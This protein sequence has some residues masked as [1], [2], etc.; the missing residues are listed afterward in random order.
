MKIEAI[1][2]ACE[3]L[4]MADNAGIYFPLCAGASGSLFSASVDPSPPPAPSFKASCWPPRH[5]AFRG[6]AQGSPAAAAAATATTAA[7]AAATAAAAATTAAATAT[8]A[9]ATAT[10]AAVAAEVLRVRTCGSS[11]ALHVSRHL[12]GRVLLLPRVPEAGAPQPS[13]SGYLVWAVQAS[14]KP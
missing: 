13:S 3:L 5:H 2:F 10:A 1:V 9:A 7:T 11:V 8:T 14:G 4:T 6:G 12:W